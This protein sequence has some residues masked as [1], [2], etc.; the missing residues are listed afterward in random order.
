MTRDGDTSKGPPK[1]LRPAEGPLLAKKRPPVK[2][3]LPGRLRGADKGEEP[4]EPLSAWVTLGWI[5]ALSGPL[6]YAVARLV[7][8]TFYGRFHVLPG[9]VGLGYSALVAPALV[10]MLATAITGGLI[11]LAGR[12]LIVTGAATSIAGLLLK[13]A[14]VNLRGLLVLGA[15]LIV[16]GLLWAVGQLATAFGRPVWMFGLCL[17]VVAAAVVAVRSAHGATE[18]VAR[19]EQVQLS[20]PGLPLTAIRATRVRLTGVE[21][22]DKRYNPPTHCLM[23]LGSSGGVAVL[24]DGPTVWRVPSD[25]A[26]IAGGC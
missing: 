19:G 10:V 2:R 22:A 13:L 8:E 25:A 17:V 26:R 12:I 6:A 4:A 9:E 1:R 3:R 23:F 11:I 5:S 18:R 20:V 7:A 14:D 21:T 24:V 15:G 16:L